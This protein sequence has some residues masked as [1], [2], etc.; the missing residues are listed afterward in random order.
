MKKTI[1]PILLAGA[2]LASCSDSKDGRDKDDPTPPGTEATEKPYADVE[3]LAA[4]KTWTLSAPETDDMSALED[5]A[6]RLNAGVV[7]NYSSLWKNDQSG[8]YSFSPVSISVFLGALSQSVDGQAREDLSR[9]LGVDVADIASLNNKLLRYLQKDE[10]NIQLTLSN[11][12]WHN[13]SMPVLDS[14][15][16]HMAGV[17]GAPVNALDLSTAESVDVLNRWGSDKTHGMIEEFVTEPLN[18]DFLIANALYFSSGWMYPFDASRT[19]EAAFHGLS[20]DSKADMMHRSIEADHALVD[21]TEYVV[22]PFGYGYEM[23]ILLPGADADSEA[24][25]RTLDAGLLREL[26]SA[27]ETKRVELSLPRFRDDRDGDIRG[28]LVTLGYPAYDMSTTVMTGT[29]DYPLLSRGSLVKH[30]TAINVNEK[31]A[32]L[33]AITAAGWATSAGNEP[34]YEPVRMNVDRPFYYIIRNTT[35]NAI[36][37]MGRVNNL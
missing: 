31:G 21:G 30:V 1:I 20:G 16:E 32:E 28:M 11:S 6:F 2:L 34:E 22:L 8:N 25:G 24:F 7:E 5:F 9:M 15:R 18:V 35:C 33:A 36:L 17:F 27:S 19:T 37:M 14:Y 13:P 10:P 4:M 29:A 26:D 23:A 3:P 12:V